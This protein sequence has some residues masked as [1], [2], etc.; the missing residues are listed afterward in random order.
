MENFET[1]IKK[2]QIRIPIIQRDY[3]QGR[4]NPKTTEIRTNFLNSIYESLSEHKGLHLDFIYG[5]I[6]N[7]KFIPLDGQ[8]RLTTLFL[9]YWYFGKKENKEIGYLA[10][11]S[12]ETRASSREFCSKLTK[13]EID[14]SSGYISH[15]IIDSSWFLA[16]WEND[17]TVRAMLT[18]I[19]AI[20]QKFEEFH[21]Y[22]NLNQITFNFFELKDFGLD[23]DLY[24]KMNARGK[25]LTEFENFKAKFE[26]FLEEVDEDLKN[27]FSLKIDND[28][29]DIF[30]EYCVEDGS[31]LVD[32]FIMNY[33]VYIAEMLHYKQAVEPLDFK[34]D[35]RQMTNIF[36]AQ[37]NLQFLF[38]SLD[39]LGVILESFDDIFSKNQYEESRVCLFD[40]S[41]N[42]AERVIKGKSINIQHRILLFII[43]SHLAVSKRNMELNELIRVVQSLKSRGNN[44]PYH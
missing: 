2:Y 22:D 23:D 35:F 14:F 28:W 34:L 8:Q 4:T 20:H 27:E 1:V 3:A 42:L 31:Y 9:L 44:F 30:W 26:Q 6:Q 24:I 7:G 41:I 15:S 17:P 33:I 18:M 25:S 40:E 21:F 29:T 37:D 10:N 36:S 13:A 12:Y 43:I 19:D 11:F 16:F 38:R 5:S 39:N 32:E